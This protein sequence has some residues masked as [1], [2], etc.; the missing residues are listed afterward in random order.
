MSMLDTSRV[1]GNS[2]GKPNQPATT[3]APL[4]VADLNWG[5]EE[6][7]ETRARL[8]ALEADWDAPGMDA[9]DNL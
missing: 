6:A 3:A 2:P 8:A 4:L 5:P 9:Y 1:T 7:Q